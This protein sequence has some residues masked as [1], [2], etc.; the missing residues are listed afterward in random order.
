MPSM[1]RWWGMN[2]AVRLIGMATIESLN[3]AFRKRYK[4]VIPHE[5][6]E[7]YFGTNVPKYVNVRQALA[8]M[9][10]IVD[11]GLIDV[12]AGGLNQEGSWVDPQ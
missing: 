9:N 4:L 8:E 1:S 11:G 10:P 12:V 3:E 2:D 5:H 6:R 7:G